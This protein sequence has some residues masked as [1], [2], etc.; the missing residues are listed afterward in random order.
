[1]T[2]DPTAR[3]ANIKDSLKKFFVDN[4]FRT[5]GIPLSFDKALSS[6]KLQGQT[7]VTRWVSVRLDD[8]ELDTLSTQDLSIYCCTRGDRE[9]YRLAQTVDTVMGYLTD[10]TQTDGFKRIPFYRSYETQPWTLLG[11]MLVTGHTLSAEQEALDETKFRIIT[12]TLRFASK[13]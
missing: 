2:L 4:I 8:L 13:V 10:N 7:A 9:G 6:P 11:A 3:T 1:V 5:S 12:V